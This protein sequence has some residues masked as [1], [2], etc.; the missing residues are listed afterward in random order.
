MAA[1]MGPQRH[2]PARGGLWIC[3]AEDPMDHSQQAGSCL[4]QNGAIRRRDPPNRDDGETQ[5]SVRGA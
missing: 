2:I 3:L 5:T 1:E 4:E